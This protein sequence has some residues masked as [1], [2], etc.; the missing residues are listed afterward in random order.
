LS[1]TFRKPSLQRFT[2]KDYINSGRYD[3]AE[4][5]ASPILT[6]KAWQRDMQEAHAAGDWDRFMEIAVAHRQNII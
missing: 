4:A 6:L 2:H 3:R 1:M 5:I